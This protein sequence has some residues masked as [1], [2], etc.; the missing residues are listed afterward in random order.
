MVITLQALVVITLQALVVI[1]LQALVVITVPFSIR[2]M[3]AYMFASSR[4]KI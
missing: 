3:A 1:T 4:T 2:L